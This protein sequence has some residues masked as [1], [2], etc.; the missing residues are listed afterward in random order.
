MCKDLQ[1]KDAFYG[2]WCHLVFPRLPDF[3]LGRW[4]DIR[5]KN[6][7]FLAINQKSEK[8]RL[9]FATNRRFFSNANH[10]NWNYSQVVE[11]LDCLIFLELFKRYKHIFIIT[12]F[13]KIKR[14]FFNNEIIKIIIFFLEANFPMTYDPSCPCVLWMVSRSVFHDF[15]KGRKVTLPSLLLEHLLCSLNIVFFLKMLWCFWTLSVSNTHQAVLSWSPK[16]ISLSH[17]NI[18]EKPGKFS[19]HTDGSEFRIYF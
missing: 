11:T 16:E 7:R 6:H 19:T 3:H 5:Y 8:K 2:L 17:T 15:L 13:N 12:N 9:L 1:I 4:I 10:I 18:E 14:T